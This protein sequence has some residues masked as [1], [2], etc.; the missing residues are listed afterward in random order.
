MT[1]V[2]L[3]RLWETQPLKQA[4]PAWLPVRVN[5]AHPLALDLVSCYLVV[6]RIAVDLMGVGPNLLGEANG[7]PS[8]YQNG[9]AWN[10]GNAT[11]G[12]RGDAPPALKIAGGSLSVMWEG[13][14]LFNPSNYLS[15]LFGVTATFNDTSPYIAYGVYQGNPGAPNTGH[16]GHIGFTGSTYPYTSTNLSVGPHTVIFTASG[17]TGL[18]YT[19]G[20]QS[21]SGPTATPSYPSA[22]IYM[23]GY[24]SGRTAGCSSRLGVVWKRALSANDAAFLARDPYCLLEPDPAAFGRAIIDGVP[25]FLWERQRRMS[26]LLRR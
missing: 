23:G 16:G 8:I 9:A 19:D 7:L 18:C 12:L 20:V 15:Y 11:S 1:Q 4:P 17:T 25:M 6:G 5:M 14:I 26:S 21:A 13:E 10:S 3:N 24:S 22:L 2:L